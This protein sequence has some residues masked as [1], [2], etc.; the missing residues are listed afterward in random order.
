MTS[1]SS[2]T[3][4]N[5]TVYTNVGGVTLIT[6]V[7]LA[8]PGINATSSKSNLAI[9]SNFLVGVP[10]IDSGTATLLWDALSTAQQ[11]AATSTWSTTAQSLADFNFTP[12]NISSTETGS[13]T[14]FTG[15]DDPYNI[16]ANDYSLSATVSAATSKA[17]NTLV[18]QSLSGLVYVDFEADPTEVAANNPLVSAALSIIEGR[19]GGSQ[20]LLGVDTSGNGTIDGASELLSALSGQCTALFSASDLV[21]TNSLNLGNQ[22]N[23]G[24][25]TYDLYFVAPDGNSTDLTS[26]PSGFISGTAATIHLSLIQDSSNRY[27]IDV[28]V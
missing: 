27:H 12:S 7:T 23:V 22:Y 26:G 18:G 2:L 20:G 21:A 9:P 4:S 6:P 15:N 14:K 11:Q 19:A 8:N 17:V 10:G 3:S 5:S 28:S 1:T 24:G 25:S 13:A 16:T